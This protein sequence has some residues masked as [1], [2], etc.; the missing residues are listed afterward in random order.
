MS[1]RI[2]PLLLAAAFPVFCY[3]ADFPAKEI[4][5][6]L[7]PAVVVIRGSGSGVVGSLGAGSI[8]SSDGLI[9]TNAHLVIEKQSKKP[10]P[11]IFIYLK[12][13]R[14]TGNYS[15]DLSRY[16]SAKVVHYSNELDLALLQA[17]DL[18]SRINSIELADPSEIK[19]GEEVAAI[20]HP[21]QGGFWSLTYGRISG[22]LSDYEGVP[23]KDVYQTDTNINRGNSGGPL[24]DRRGYLVAINSNIARIGNEGIPIT[25]VNFAIKSSV[26]KQWLAKRGFD[27]AYGKRPLIE[28]AL[29]PTPAL[30][31][32]AKSVEKTPPIE[33]K[34]S[35]AKVQEKK[36]E[37][38]PEEKKAEP[39]KPEDRILTQRRPYNYD[40]VLKAA[41]R[42]LEDM[43][44]EMSEKLRR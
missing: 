17:T 6:A 43:M 42:E 37:P 2:P 30:E 27:I 13:N 14:L 32:K 23:G 39:Q 19:V 35:E 1:R 10:Y 4:Y 34:K 38:K 31:T 29:K 28:V 12:P 21:E 3:A 25:G 7:S 5:E 8:V 22:E 36:P 16:F 44:K 15:D 20:G 33:E 26:A 40:A 11:A 24:L 18:P 41:E 9:I